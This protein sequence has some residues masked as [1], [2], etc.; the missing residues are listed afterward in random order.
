MR[1]SEYC[2]AFAPK[3]QTVLSELSGRTPLN[4]KANRPFGECFDSHTKAVYKDLWEALLTSE[5]IIDQQR[6]MLLKNP[7]FDIQEAFASFCSP[8]GNKGA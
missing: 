8:D 6:Q 2:D 3:S 7:N 5:R 4:L 1:Y